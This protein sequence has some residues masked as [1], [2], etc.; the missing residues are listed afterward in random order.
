MR[1][2]LEKKGP[3]SLTAFNGSSP[4][5]RDFGRPG[6]I[7]PAA[8]GR[9]RRSKAAPARA[10][11]P[12]RWARH[13]AGSSAPCGPHDSGRRTR[14]P[15]TRTELGRE[16]HAPIVVPTSRETLDRPGGAHTSVTSACARP[17]FQPRARTA[18]GPP[19]P[20]RR[21][22]RQQRRTAIWT[23]VRHVVG[24]LIRDRPP[25]TT[26]RS[27]AAA[28][29]RRR[30]AASTDVSRLRGSLICRG[31]AVTAMARGS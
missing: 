15:R 1:S 4:E 21:P 20:S 8:Q 12:P 25:D 5:E 10:I 17:R 19:P 6:T 26:P 18:R 31:P 30:H 9:A 28:R 16:R 22:R 14:T 3:S 27:I 29:A 13:T 11:G 7:V 23:H 24:P 2:G